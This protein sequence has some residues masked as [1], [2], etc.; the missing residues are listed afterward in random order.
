MPLKIVYVAAKRSFLYFLISL[1]IKA[2]CFIEEHEAA[3]TDAYNKL[4]WVT[5]TVVSCKDGEGMTCSWRSIQVQSQIKF[6]F[7]MGDSS[8]LVSLE[9]SYTLKIFEKDYMANESLYI[10]KAM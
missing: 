7:E 5:R 4:F 10:T 1:N 6:P 3:M 8:R 2:T 9:K